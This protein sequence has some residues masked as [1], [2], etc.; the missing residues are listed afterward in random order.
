MPIVKSNKTF[1]FIGFVLLVM[2]V[3]LIQVA[4]L[5]IFDETYKLS[6]DNISVRRVV[7]YPARGLIFDRDGRIL[8]YN[9]P[10]YELNCIPSQIG[11][12][13][14]AYLCNVLKI[15]K[16]TL[17]AGIAEAKDYSSQR[18]SKVYGPFDDT[19]YFI[20]QEQMHR[21]PGFSIEQRFERI[22]P[23]SVAPHLL[24]YIR[25]V[26]KK[27]VDT[28]SY[29]AAGDIIGVAGI[30]KSYENYLR[31]KKGVHFFMVDANNRV[32]GRYKD[33]RFDTSAVVGRNLTCTIDVDLQRYCEKLMQN[34]RGAIVVIQPQT[35]EVLAMVSSPSYDPNLLTLSNLKY[36]Y[37]LLIS[38]YENRPM[39]NRA[40]GAATSP[41]GSTFK[42]VDA[43][44]GLNEQVITPQT[45]IGCHGG[46]R[47]SASHIV[48]CHHNA[49]IDFYHSIS[50][51]CNT[52]YCEV[53]TRILNNKKYN[54]VE[55]AYKHWYEQL[56]KFGIGVKLGID[57]PGET[58]GILYSAKR[59]NAIHGK[60]KWGT[61]KIISLAIGQG[62]LGLTTLQLANVAAIIANRGWYITPHVVRFIE[63]SEIK[64]I[65]KQKK[66]VDIDTAY[67][68]EVI[69][70][71]EQVV[72]FGTAANIRL[73]SLSQCGKTGTAQNPHGD[74]NSVFIEFAPK[75]NPQVAIG[76]Y[77]ENG[78]Y[79]ASTAAPIA[80][81]IAEKYIT[82]TITRPWLEEMIINK[83][84]MN[85]GQR[86]DR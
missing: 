58:S 45:V 10:Y 32:V 81:L 73:D 25:E 74:Y 55:D 35:G 31:G 16:E 23:Y 67:F 56:H 72:L 4:Y 11:E 77:V 22:Y 39:F 46:F 52:Y 69:E 8:V 63:D 29:Y 47:I 15:N 24:G 64:P 82:D 9:R 21:F 42:V 70:G 61:Y 13:D 86:T 5:Q 20:L 48:G 7:E 83:N 38:D 53:F 26:D 65:Y 68:H 54:T 37:P 66:Y 49:P 62:E 50:G 27:I 36:N 59:Y 51:S 14:T 60:G 75:E 18:P 40:L 43:L 41:P 57:L 12:F 28:S 85:R 44:I 71:M 80:S 30:E 3:Y 19:T 78:G 17:E 6:A 79:G 33:G 34:K 1:V 84:L 2:I 76:V